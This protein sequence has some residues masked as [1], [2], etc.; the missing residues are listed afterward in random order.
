MSPGTAKGKLEQRID[1]L[2]AKVSERSEEEEWRER[3][4]H[5]KAK[6]KTLVLSVFHE[7]DYFC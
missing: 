6:N 3:S 1:R 2:D 5:I 7:D 4:A